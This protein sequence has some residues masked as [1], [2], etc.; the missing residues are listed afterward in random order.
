MQ[1]IAEEIYQKINNKVY[2]LEGGRWW[3][4]DFSLNLIKTL[5]NPVRVD[6]AKEKI[7]GIKLTNKRKPQLL[8]VGCGGGILLEE[9]TEMGFTVTGV[10]PS[11][12]SLVTAV[13]HSMKRNLNIRFV[14]GSGESLPFQTGTFDVV[15]CCDVLEHVR[16][17]PKVISEISRVLKKDGILVYDT[18]NRNIFSKIGVVKI[19]QDWKRW[20]IMPPDLHVWEMFIKPKEMK[21]LLKA[22]KLHW[23]EH[24]GIVPDA[25][26]LKILHYLRKRAIGYLTYEEFGR[27]FHM[28]EGKSTRVMYMGYAIKS[29]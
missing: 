5:L 17:L 9:F 4:T 15:L 8:E 13:E 7:K 11:V 3:H 25:P 2:D 19:M 24:R 20:S 16:D 26:Y 10:D 6:Y 28:I 1:K 21:A 22:N 14:K 18:F 29:E 12:S 27:K 23:K